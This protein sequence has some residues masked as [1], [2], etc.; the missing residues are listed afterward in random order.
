M[1]LMFIEEIVLFRKSVKAG[2]LHFI[3]SAADRWSYREI[4]GYCGAD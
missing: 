1:S 4:S 2:S 3:L